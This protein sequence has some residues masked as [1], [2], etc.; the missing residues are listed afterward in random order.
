MKIK[1]GN[2]INQN[3]LD[4]GWL[5]SNTDF[6]YGNNQLFFTEFQPRPSSFIEDLKSILNLS[7]LDGLTKRA[8]DVSKLIEVAQ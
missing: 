3:P 5:T 6:H 7:F 2:A 1:L 4:S 8:Y